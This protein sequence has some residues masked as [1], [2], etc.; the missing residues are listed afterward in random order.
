MLCPEYLRLKKGEIIA[1]TAYNCA[2]YTNILGYDE[3]K[4][5]RVQATLASAE[6]DQHLQTCLRCKTA[7]SA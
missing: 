1:W 2:R 4:R 6:V 3:L 7:R 5:R